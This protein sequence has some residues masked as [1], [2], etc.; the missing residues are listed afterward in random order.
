MKIKR[1]DR[2][3][4]SSSS[5]SK[6]AR[7]EEAEDFSEGSS[8]SW[9]VQGLFDRV[10]DPAGHVTRHFCVRR[11]KKEEDGSSSNSSSSSNKEV[12]GFAVTLCVGTVDYNDC[13]GGPAGVDLVLTPR[14]LEARLTLRF[15]TVDRFQCAT[16]HWRHSL[17]GP[18]QGN[19]WSSAETDQGRGK[20]KKKNGNTHKKK[21]NWWKYKF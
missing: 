21:K 3:T 4:M 7:V 17:S 19:G 11:R 14:D 15:S 10:R 12:L 9:T 6:S 5:P 16:V 1:L 18:S 2:Q 8:F 13:S 20:K